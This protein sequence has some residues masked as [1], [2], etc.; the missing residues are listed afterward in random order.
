MTRGKKPSGTP[1]QFE[2]EAATRGAGRACERCGR[3]MVDVHVP[4]LVD[5]GGPRHAVGRRCVACGQVIDAHSLGHHPHG[6]LGEEE[7]RR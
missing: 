3:L 5:E 1:G 7:Q 6:D 2:Y 4:T